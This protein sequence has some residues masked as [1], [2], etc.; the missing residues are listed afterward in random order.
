M[1]NLNK[2]DE[3]YKKYGDNVHSDPVRFD[4]IA[5]LCKGLVL[6]VACG[7]GDL[8]DFYKGSYIGI[9]I[10][11]TAITMARKIRRKDAIFGVGDVLKRIYTTKKQYDTVVIAE[12]LEHIHNDDTL[13]RN[14]KK[15]TS[16]NGRWIISVPNG[17]RVPDKDHV[18]QFTVPQLRAKF[19]KFGKVK[20]H[21]YNGFRER[22][23]LTVDLNQNNDNKLS[24]VMP[25]KNEGKGLETA[26]LSCIGFVDNIVISVDKASK[27]N[28]LKI[29]EKY[30]D[31]LK[32]YEWKD[33]FADARNFAQ[34]G[35]KTE[36]CLAL[37]GHEYVDA[38]SK[39]ENALK[40]DCDG[41]FVK[42][43]MEDG[44]SFYSPRI[45]KSNIKWSKPVHNYPETTKN[46]RYETFFI[47]HDRK[48]LQTKKFIVE[49]AKQRDEQILRILNE[50]VKE[51]KKD[52]RSIFYLA[53]HWQNRGNKKIA[54][55]YFKKYL[56]CADNK[57]EMWLVCYYIGRCWNTLN[58]PRKAIKALKSANKYIPDR[59]EIKKEI[60][61]TYMILKKWHKASEYLVNSFDKNKT[62][63]IFN[64]EPDNKA[65]TWYLIAQ[66]F[67]NL[68]K[69]DQ[70]RIAMKQ[71]KQTQTKTKFG[72]LPKLQRKIIDALTKN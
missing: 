32:I 45:I 53:Q 43:I 52:H 13:L 22:I 11:Q 65:G 41:L 17:D 44:F 29:A 46:V 70:A 3:F 35:I 31:T 21:N 62:P 30:A 55:K 7:T 54:I 63:F 59:Q 24:L 4:A 33:D 49:R 64:P 56:K 18:R 2:N 38:C 1:K 28:T 12:F 9:D 57:E 61:A 37:D 48:N 60:G 8:A 6:D 26:I 36:W 58:K 67:Y 69:F 23:L 20:F 51:N 5:K 71:A 34:K 27:D 72:K 40:Q 10:S 25:V 15:E 16:I 66:C 39:L 14:L 19:S 47:V 68:G 50:K 42:V